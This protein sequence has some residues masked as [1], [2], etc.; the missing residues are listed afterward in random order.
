VVLT[1]WQKGDK[2][3]LDS[4]PF[5]EQTAV[6][7]DVKQNHYVLVLESLGCVLKIKMTFLLHFHVIL[8]QPVC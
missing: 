5:A 4:G 8:R 3:I 2:V 7:Q 1:K 6:V